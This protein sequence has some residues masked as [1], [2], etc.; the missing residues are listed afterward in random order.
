M[1]FVLAVILI[2]VTALVGTLPQIFLIG[3]RI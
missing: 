1:H 3:S 2:F